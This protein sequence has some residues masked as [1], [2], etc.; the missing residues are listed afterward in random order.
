V[1]SN[2]T[3]SDIYALGVLLYE[4]LT[5]H[6]PF[7]AKELV[8]S[9]LDEIRRTI[10]EV[11]PPRPSTRLSTMMNADLTLVA[12]RHGAEPAKFSNL[13]GAKLCRAVTVDALGATAES[14]SGEP[15]C[16][17][18][19]LSLLASLRSK[20]GWTEPLAR[21]PGGYAMIRADS[22]ALVRPNR[23]AGRQTWGC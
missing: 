15:G 17:R 4:L 5:G 1:R 2:D 16:Q 11:E 23:S 19:M 22:D 7:D 12:K 10:R 20:W 18:E 13:G 14:I 21:R 6:T 3:R 9:G 8:Q